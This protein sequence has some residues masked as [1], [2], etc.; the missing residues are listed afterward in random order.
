MEHIDE[1]TIHAW[2]DGA[3]PSDE[4]ARIEAHVASCTACAIAVAEA[5]GLIAASSRILSALDEVPGGVIPVQ[6]V[7]TE[8]LTSGRAPGAAARLGA[9]GDSAATQT[10]RERGAV[11]GAAN[12]ARGVHSTTRQPRR[13]W[14]RQPQWA[15][16]A[17]LAFLA[18]AGTTVVRRSGSPSVMDSARESIQSAPM[19]AEPRA[20]L[21]ADAAASSTSDALS[22]SAR[23]ADAPGAPGQRAL[24]ETSAPAGAATSN[25]MKKDAG[26]GR[27]A[28]K[29]QAE[30]PAIAK[31]RVTSASPERRASGG[32]ARDETPVVPVPAAPLPSIVASASV[33]SRAKRMM[34]SV[35]RNRPLSLAADAITRDDSARVAGDARAQRKAA[36][37][38]LESVVVTGASSAVTRATLR[39]PAARLEQ[40]GAAPPVTPASLA[41]CYLVQ[42][43]D[44]ARTVG[45][46]SLLQLEFAG[47]GSDEARPAYSARDLGAGNVQP[48]S[49]SSLLRWTLSTSG[50]VV[51]VRGEG[52]MAQRVTLRIGRTPGDTLAAGQL[53]GTRTACPAR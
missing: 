1:G 53:Q 15:A 14:Y 34:D 23:S 17:G 5:R 13:P 36:A 39:P 27:A 48:S 18:L 29:L 40:A 28:G 11:I 47:A 44:V 2:L 30:A 7:T 12:A 33:E 52:A 4:T 26:A 19:A 6:V 35:A 25:E 3:L 21:A 32:N 49:A 38:A 10:H 31:L 24:A 20:D 45:A 46:G 42:P 50:E 8:S 16:A 37:S 9:D 51:L 43:A 22:A 41:G